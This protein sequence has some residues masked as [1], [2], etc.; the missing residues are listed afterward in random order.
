LQYMIPMA[1]LICDISLLLHIG[2]VWVSS[3]G[4]TVRVGEIHHS[5][6][7]IYAWGFGG[8]KDGQFWLSREFLR[9]AV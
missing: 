4:I 9:D 2:T 7:Q 6:S 3:S 8:R 5:N 1:A